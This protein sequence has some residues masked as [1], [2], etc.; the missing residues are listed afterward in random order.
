M[1]SR[2][3]FIA[4]FNSIYP[5]PEKLMQRMADELEILELDE[6][7]F[8]LR[9]DQ[10]S[11]YASCVL[12]GLMR[13]YYFIKDDVEVTSRFTAEK[14]MV[15]SVNSFYSRRP[16]YEYVKAEEDTRLIRMSYTMHQEL[17]DE[18]LEYNYIVRT[19]TEQYYTASEEHLFMLRKKS[20]Q[21]KWTYFENTY[22]DLIPRVQLRHVASFLGMTLETLSRVR[23]QSK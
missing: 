6:R 17:L 21:E 22:P 7:D 3:D 23:S 12:S 4:Y 5:M 2:Q 10:V 9:E 19:L 14:G 13:S 18:F 1:Q 11:N 8:L 16:G 20:A 15:L